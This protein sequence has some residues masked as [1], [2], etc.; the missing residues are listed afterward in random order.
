MYNNDLLTFLYQAGNINAHRVQVYA[1]APPYLYNDHCSTS[2]CRM[3]LVTDNKKPFQWNEPEGCVYSEY[4]QAA[5]T[6]PSRSGG[7]FR[8]F[9]RQGKIIVHHGIKTNIE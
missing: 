3:I 7:F 2:P 6:E 8:T 1:S 4:S 5:K 9:F